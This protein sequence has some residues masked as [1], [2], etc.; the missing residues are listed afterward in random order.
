MDRATGAVLGVE[1]VEAHHQLPAGRRVG[2]DCGFLRDAFR[3][4]DDPEE[5]IRGQHRRPEHG[6][7]KRIVAGDI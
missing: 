6:A 2:D 7:A 3:S 5:K 1:A 4:G